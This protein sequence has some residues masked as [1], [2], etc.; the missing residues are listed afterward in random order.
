MS[1]ALVVIS[2]N[3]DRSVYR[4]ARYQRGVPSRAYTAPE[5]LPIEW[6]EVI[7]ET[8]EILDEEDRDDDTPDGPP[9]GETA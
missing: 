7:R 4:Y 1:L 8:P 5:A 3:W 2:N 6:V 9:A